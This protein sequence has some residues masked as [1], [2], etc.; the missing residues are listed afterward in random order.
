M[1]VLIVFSVIILIKLI[2]NLSRL[3]ETYYLFKVFKKHPKSI[4]QY[5]PF[6][7]SLFN[8]AGTNE[9]IIATTRTNGLNQARRDYISNSLGKKDSYYSLEVIFQK[10]IGVYKYR[11]VQTLNPFYWLFLP[12]YVFYYLGKP[13]KT[14]LE[15]LFN[16]IYWFATVVAAYLVE[17]FLSANL[18]HWI[19]LLSDKL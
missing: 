14:P 9:I 8:S 17:L 10:T 16:L 12:R 19:Q 4:Y 6:V 13:L 15:I 11:L 1:Y 3:I 7:T 2:L 18:P 5:T